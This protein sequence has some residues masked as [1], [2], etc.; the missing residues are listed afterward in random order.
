MAEIKVDIENL[1]KITQQ[2]LIQLS[3]GKLLYVEHNT[4]GTVGVDMN[5]VYV[6][7]VAITKKAD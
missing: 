7:T 1:V 6:E 4:K 2:E 5:N 3:E